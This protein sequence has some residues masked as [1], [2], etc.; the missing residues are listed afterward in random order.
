M[1]GV[2]RKR[3]RPGAE[4]PVREEEDEESVWHKLREFKERKER[5]KREAAAKAGAAAAEVRAAAA[6]AHIPAR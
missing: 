4:E 2:A 6:W 5:K 3:P 1:D